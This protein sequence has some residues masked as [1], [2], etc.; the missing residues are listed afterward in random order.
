MSYSEAK[1]EWKDGFPQTLFPESSSTACRH[2]ANLKSDPQTKAPT[3]VNRTFSQND[4]WCVSVCC[5]LKELSAS[6]Y[7]F[8]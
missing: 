2:V 5:V 4:S 8:F 3:Q 1:G 6:F 7:V